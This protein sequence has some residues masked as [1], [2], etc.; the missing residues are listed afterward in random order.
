MEEPVLFR[1]AKKIIQTCKKFKDN[2][3]WWDSSWINDSE[4]IDLV[5]HQIE[6]LESVKELVQQ[7]KIVEG[8]ILIRTV[9]ENYF[10]ISLILNGT[11][12]KRKYK[13]DKEKNETQEE[14]YRRIEIELYKQ[15]K[16]GKKDIVS[17]KA[18]DKYKKIEITYTG[19]YSEDGERLIPA[20]YF[21]FKQYD[22][23]IHRIDK[24]KSIRS[25]DIF[26]EHKEKWQKHHQ[27]LYNYYL[28]PQN[29]IECSILNNI[30]SEERKERFY[31]HYNF[32]SGFSHLTQKGYD[33]THEHG[34]DKNPHYLKELSLLYIIKLS[35][36]YLSLLLKYFK[37]VKIKIKN[38][39]NFTEQINNIDLLFSYFW[40]IY[41][42][43]SDFD[44]YMYKT[45]KTYYKRRG[46]DL[47]DIIPY[48]K[49]PYE[50]IKNQHRSTYEL[51]TGES[52]TPPWEKH[53]KYL[54]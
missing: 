22:P 42:E 2:V 29:L 6:I 18:L 48:Y 39:E 19:Y 12:Y 14:A 54:F 15:I 43:H 1:E 44:E 51:S 50:R 33:L 11:K 26:H 27:Y 31:V 17:F 40:F 41:N 30:I 47:D 45:S 9:F 25:K 32:L 7:N 13:V 16:N 24:I 10:I 37:R 4:A 36:Y 21:V 20:Y 52:W 28:K 49:N 53:T 8:L 46:K 35:C 5:I 34:W 3:Q 23:I 38:E